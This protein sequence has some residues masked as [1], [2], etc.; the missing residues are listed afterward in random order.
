MAH[1]IAHDISKSSSF[2]MASREILLGVDKNAS[3]IIFLYVLLNGFVTDHSLHDSHHKLWLSGQTSNS[4]ME[5][6]SF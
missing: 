2:V 3:G 1:Y 4:Y 6:V 5:L